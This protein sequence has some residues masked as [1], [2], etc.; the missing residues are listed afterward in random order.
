MEALFETGKIIIETLKKA[1]FEAYFVGGAVRDY[2]MLRSIHDVDIT[3][4]A[5]PADVERLFNQTIDVGKEHGTIVVLIHRTPF[6]VTT[7]RTETSYTDYRR[8]DQ[9]MF[10]AQLEEDLR[11]RDFTMN[12]M[13]M[14]EDY[15][16]HDPY[17][18]IQSIKERTIQTVG[19]AR[20]RFSEDA[21]RMLR[22]IRFMSTLKF[23]LSADTSAA[24][25][26][27]KET[28]FYV[29]IERIIVELR[30]MYHGE[31][32]EAAKTTLENTGLIKYIPFFK[33]IKQPLTATSVTDMVDEIFL[34][35]HFNQSLMKFLNELKLP[36][37]DKRVI[38]NML[39]LLTDLNQGINSVKIAFDYER[40]ILK[41]LAGI[42]RCNNI[43]NDARAVLLQKAIQAQPALPIHSRQDLNVDGKV[44]M[45]VFNLK[46][47]PWIKALLSILEEAVLFNQLQNDQDELIEWVRS[48]VI[49][50]DGNIKIIK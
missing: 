44:L 30:K 3:T 13:A 24:I 32:I 5:K 20:E 25:T 46:G 34:Q 6:E 12:A 40:I 43:I 14:S 45:E 23:T 35:I 1:G 2:V 31:N 28:L 42:D 7:Y 18:G 16:V 37:N 27:H 11:R 50:K 21:L 49:I 38:K 26:A 47:G 36:N 19:E 41:K 39:Q 15:T 10:T 33:E 17:N 8:P 4:N 48:Y 9:I 29:A 22:A